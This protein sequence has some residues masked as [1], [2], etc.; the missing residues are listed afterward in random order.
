MF[1]S[2]Q[3]AIII[4]VVGL[5]LSLLSLFVHDPNFKTISRILG[6]GTFLFAL[7]LFFI[8]YWGNLKSNNRLTE[9]I[10]S[11]EVEPFISD[12]I[13][14]NYIEVE[15]DLFELY[16]KNKIIGYII[17]PSGINKF[18]VLEFTKGLKTEYLNYL[19]DKNS[20]LKLLGSNINYCKNDNKELI[21]IADDGSGRWES[22]S[23]LKF[24]LSKHDLRSLKMVEFWYPVTYDYFKTIG[25]IEF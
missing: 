20:F 7:A 21:I 4:G 12:S 25:K 24:G 15:K 18:N 3:F 5:F 2:D 13:K 8:N 19:A 10:E 11:V 14:N 9:S 6:V 16:Y 23:K 22:G 17:L 1:T